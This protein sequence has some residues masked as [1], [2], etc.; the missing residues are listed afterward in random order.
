MT[1][2]PH[3]KEHP[4]SVVRTAFRTKRRNLLS[5]AYVSSLPASARGN[6]SQ[7]LDWDHGGVDKDLMEIAHHM[8][9]WEEQL[10]A[11]LELTQ[12]DIHDIN[13]IYSNQPE[14]QR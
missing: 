14:L 10:S 4:I 3:L 5:A 2:L 1:L 11:L 6:L 8:L 7:L 12:V 13:R 9:G